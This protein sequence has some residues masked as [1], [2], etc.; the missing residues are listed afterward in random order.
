MRKPA[1]LRGW[2]SSYKD[3]KMQVCQGEPKLSFQGNFFF[4]KPLF[5]KEQMNSD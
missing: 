5:Q 3:N 1:T 2:G 4:N